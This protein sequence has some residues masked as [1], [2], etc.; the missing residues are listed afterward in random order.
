MES[1]KIL[2]VDD[3]REI[4]DLLAEFLES[5]GLP[6]A[7]AE[8]GEQ[9]RQRIAADRPDLVVLDLTLPGEDG[10]ALCREL[11]AGSRI[12]IIM[13]TARSAPVDR[14]VG[15]EM[16]ADDYLTKPFEPRELVARIRSVLRRSETQPAVPILLA[17]RNLKF[18]QWQFDLGARHLIDCAGTVI[19]LSSGEYRLLREFLQHPN[20]VLSRD[21]LLNVV[22]GRDNDAF[23]R[24]IDL[25]VSRLR[26]KLG[27][28]ARTPQLIKTI[29]NEG[30]L[31][32]A[33]VTEG[34]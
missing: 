20:H 11:I 1:A 6:T 15:L 9:M 16:G 19:S 21:Q 33:A 22:S 4:R 17:P 5:H 23:D 18:A 8:N 34:S 28:D 30:Y 27:D 31:F 10:L 29:R 26:Q 13:L 3:D 32:T 25:Q 24:S 12:P 14:I 2:I 7:L